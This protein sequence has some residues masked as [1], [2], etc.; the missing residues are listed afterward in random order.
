MSY[1]FPKKQFMKT[2]NT[3]AGLL[4]I[5]CCNFLI[6]SCSKGGSSGYGSTNNTGGTTSS[7]GNTVS[8]YN[9]QFGTGSI[10]VKAGTTVTWTNA[11]NMIHDVIADDASFKSADMKYGDTYTHTFD[12][13]GTYAYHCSYHSGMKGTVVVN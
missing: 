3:F 6:M 8:M 13:K 9:M 5:I 11:D 10:T 2:K 7:S 1:V 12:T 4:L